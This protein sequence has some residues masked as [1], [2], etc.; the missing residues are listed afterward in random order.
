MRRLSNISKNAEKNI[1]LFN[2]INRIYND[3]DENEP[4]AYN[5]Y[6]NNNTS[7]S[8][9]ESGD[10]QLSKISLPNIKKYPYDDSFP[11]MEAKLKGKFS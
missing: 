1:K 10:Q 7:R 6:N 5:N 4:E 2:D 3:E 8:L 9:T 11:N